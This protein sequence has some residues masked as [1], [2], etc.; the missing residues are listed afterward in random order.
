MSATREELRPLLKTQLPAHWLRMSDTLSTGD[1]E[2]FACDPDEQLGRPITNLIDP[3]PGAQIYV[4]IRLEPNPSIVWLHFSI[5]DQ[6]GP[7]SRAWLI[8]IANFLLS[9]SIGEQDIVLPTV[10]PTGDAPPD[11]GPR[12]QDL[13]LQLGARQRSANT[14]SEKICDRCRE[15]YKVYKDVNEDENADVYTAQPAAWRELQAH[16]EVSGHDLQSVI[17]DWA[18]FT[19]QESVESG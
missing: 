2:L 17:I 15:L 18:G 1:W 7:L 8:E 4:K 5:R 10:P 3:I 13:W 12:F 16:L 9:R 11:G 6:N 19:Q 14:M